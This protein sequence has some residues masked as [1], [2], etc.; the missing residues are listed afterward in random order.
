MKKPRAMLAAGL[1]AGL[2]LTGVAVPGIATATGDEPS[3]WPMYNWD[4]S[5]SRHN[6]DE[7]TLRPGNVGGLVEKWRVPVKAVHGTPTVV[8]NR[9]YVGDSN[10][11]TGFEGTFRALNADTGEVL[12]SGPASTRSQAA[13]WW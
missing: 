2:V 3:D 9:L 6:A 13:P 12:G 10:A 7:K 11:T 5:G 8:G 4:A 1:A